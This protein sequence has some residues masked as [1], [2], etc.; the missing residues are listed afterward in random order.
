MARPGWISRL[1][2]AD[3]ASR[4]RRARDS[5]NICKEFRV[6]LIDVANSSA[7]GVINSDAADGVA[8]R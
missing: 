8:A 7:E 1:L 5:M 4:L 6:R 3:R 2:L